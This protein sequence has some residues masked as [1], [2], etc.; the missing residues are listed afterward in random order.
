MNSVICV[1][2]QTELGVWSGEL[3]LLPGLV[4]PWLWDALG[5]R[6]AAPGW[7]HSLGH[8]V[9]PSFSMNLS[10]LLLLKSGASCPEHMG[11]QERALPSI[12][13]TMSTFTPQITPETSPASSPRPASSP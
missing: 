9:G 13:A 10:Q 12:P 7:P 5:C 6:A 3:L 1:W 8:L 11:A 4:P 2:S